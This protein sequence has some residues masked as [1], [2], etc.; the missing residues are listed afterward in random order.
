MLPIQ[1]NTIQDWLESKKASKSR[2]GFILPGGLLR[3]LVIFDALKPSR[4]PSGTQPEYVRPLVGGA[5]PE[6]APDPMDFI[7]RARKAEI[8]VLEPLGEQTPFEIEDL[9]QNGAISAPNQ[10]GA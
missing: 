10:A 5:E 4:C 1:S 3:L 7:P 9:G 2:T 6:T 8:Q